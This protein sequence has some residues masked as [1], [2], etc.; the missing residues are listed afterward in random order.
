MASEL[1][2]L[3]S[4]SGVE[5]ETDPFFNQVTG[6]YHF[7]GSNGGTNS[8]FIDSSTNGHTVTNNGDVTQGTFSPF[9]VADGNWSTF[10]NGGTDGTVY[11]NNSFNSFGTGDFT[12]EFWVNF[13]ELELTK[14]LFDFRSSTNTSAS[15]LHT[16][17]GSASGGWNLGDA[18]GNYMSDAGLTNND[19]TAGK[20][21]HLA[22][23]RA[24]STTKVFLDGTEKASVSDSGDYDSKDLTIGGR[25][26]GSYSIKGHISNFRMLRGTGLYTSAFTPPTTPLTNVTNTVVRGN[27]TYGF[28]DSY[29]VVLSITTNGT[30]SI[31]P[32]SP[33]AKSTAY[34]ATTNGGSGSFDRAGDYLSAQ[35]SDLAF[36]TDDF[37]VEGWVR[38]KTWSTGTGS[39]RGIF[40]ITTGYLNSTVYGPAL[41]VDDSGN[42]HIYHVSGA[43]ALAYGPAANEWTHF[44]Y[45]RNSSTS[46]VYLDGVSVWTASDSNDYT[47]SHLVV[48]GYYS[49]SF[50]LDGYISGFRIVKGTAVYTSAFTPPTSAPTAISGTELLL[51]FTNAA[52]FDSAMKGNIAV[53]G[54]AQ[55]DTSVKKF[56]T[57]SAEFDGTGDYLY[58]DS[59][60]NIGTGDFT[61]ECFVYIDTLAYDGIW[62]LDTAPLSGNPYIGPV[63]ETTFV[64]SPPYVWSTM[65]KHGG[66][67]RKFSSVTPSA[68]TWYHTAVVR[69]SGTIKVFVDGVQIITDFTDTTNFT[70]RDSLVIGGFYSTSYLMDGYIDELRVT[71]RAR[72]TTNFNPPTE[73]FPNAGK[74]L[75]A[76]TLIISYIVI[77]GGGGG[78][79]QGGSIGMY[80][81][82][83]GG[84]GG[85][86]IG[87]ANIA[88]SA[89]VA[90]TVGAGGAG[91]TGNVNQTGN[92]GTASS[93][94]T[95]STT[96]VGGG[97]GAKGAG[98]ASDGNDGGSGGGASVTGTPGSATSGQGNAGGD[99][100][101]GSPYGG[102]GGG[103]AGSVGGNAGG[104]RAGA[105]GS[106][107][108][109]YSVWASATS[110]GASGLYAGGG[111]GSGYQTAGTQGLAGSGGG[112][113][114]GSDADVAAAG[115]ANTGGGGGGGGGRAGT[116][117]SAA[118]GSGIVMIRYEGSQSATGGTIVTTGGYTYHTFTSSG[119][120][121]NNQIMS[122][123]AKVEDGIVTAVI[124]AEQDFIDKHCEGMWVQTSYNTR[125]G[126]HYGQDGKPDGG[127]ALRKN[128]AGIGYI[129]DNSKDAFYD[130]KPYPSW[131]L[132]EDS[133]IWE[134]PKEMPNDGNLYKW[135]EDTTSWVVW[136]RTG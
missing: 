111:G 15:Y 134:P 79:K 22:I 20:W 50:L 33:F 109:A 69:T 127:T 77:S 56:G 106:G 32:F 63:L 96:S 108:S 45:V 94:A 59:N 129:Y 37:T 42:W 87:T 101:S 122:H 121:T 130:Q 86:V 39:G 84:A 119:T 44:A 123:F 31:Q 46:T 133:C 114:G 2:Q 71:N 62:Q 112:G 26:S 102:G 18:D 126:I 107:T 83:G 75:A 12:I 57:A 52:I 9:S 104:T 97:G 99:G 95:I 10:Y 78:G 90:I 36:G 55:L 34:S 14:M 43:T 35:D 38:L 27:S 116:Y 3:L 24:S 58:V 66:D 11:G 105:G 61:V 5:E 40:H 4:V 60:F 82:G 13:A 70:D 54:N 135:D 74:P 72:Y 8:T 76:G 67:S 48:G 21:H 1:L 7:D 131:I 98:S 88:A 120:F 92:N 41:G 28:I 23:S 49:S 124:V 65:T 89:A 6:L 73:S 30:P 81:A 16:S 64:S 85:V 117:P 17:S 91:I 68:S 100:T 113:Q 136:E 132:N 80:G 115:T 19:F 128:Y 25:Y 29:N 103:G 53:Y 110:T 51:S 93:I 47:W 118:G 125:G